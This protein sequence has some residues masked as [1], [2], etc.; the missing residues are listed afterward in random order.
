VATILRF[1]A[2]VKWSSHVDGCIR[3]LSTNAHALPGDK[4]LCSLVKLQ[5]IA[6]EVNIAFNMDDPSAEVIFTE[7]KVQYQLNAFAHQLRSWQNEN[8]VEAGDCGS[9]NGQKPHVL[10]RNRSGATLRG[11]HE[12]IHS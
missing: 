4:W 10:T 2:L 3:F 6:E 5:R 8:R 11:L 12:F 1:P 7:P 9:L